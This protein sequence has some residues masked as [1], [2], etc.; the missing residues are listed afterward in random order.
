MA[1]SLLMEEFHLTAFVPRGLRESQYRA[2]RRALDSRRFRMDLGR[3]V[4][5]V[6]HRHAALQ[7]VRIQ[8]SR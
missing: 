2:I 5:Q 4:R 6:F 8:L 1:R 7:P 3:A